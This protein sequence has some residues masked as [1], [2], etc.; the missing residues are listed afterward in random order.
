[1][2]KEFPE[3]KSGKGIFRWGD[4]GGMNFTGRYLGVNPEDIPALIAWLQE[5]PP[6]KRW[7]ITR[8][9]EFQPGVVDRAGPPPHTGLPVFLHE[10]DVEK[11]RE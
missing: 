7:R 3:S 5:G 2:S 6:Q 11:V 1:M 9:F 8:T 10:G 4:D